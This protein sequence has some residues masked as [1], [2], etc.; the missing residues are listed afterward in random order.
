[1]GLR[2]TFWREGFATNSSSQHSMIFTDKAPTLTTT[3]TRNFG[4][5]LFTAASQEAKL[6]YMLCCLYS[7]WRMMTEID[8]YNSII[9]SENFREFRLIE[10]RKWV[11]LHVPVMGNVPSDFDGEWDWGSV[12]H[13]SR[14]TFSRYRDDQD[15][16]GLNVEF[17]EAFI[18]EFVENNYVM[19]GGNDNDEE[20]HPLV[21]EDQPEDNHLARVYSAMRERDP[22][23]LICEK[24]HLTGEFVCSDLERGRL[25]KIVITPAAGS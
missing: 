13:E 11:G 20:V 25:F 2:I 10:F 8:A 22:H 15:K 24:D 18:R 14:M 21:C 16:R 6:N 7:S 12:D 23:Y 17:A 4:W 5:S 1:M 3:E 9:P 19:L